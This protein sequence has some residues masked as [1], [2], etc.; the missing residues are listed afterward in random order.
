LDF[1]VR[2]PRA[3]ARERD[4]PRTK[5]MPHEVPC[6]NSFQVRTPTPGS[7]RRLAASRA[8]SAGLK[9]CQKSVSQRADANPMVRTVR[10]SGAVKG[11][12]VSGEIGRSAGDGARR[13]STQSAVPPRSRRV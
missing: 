11:R 6:S 8:G 3:A 9:P 2:V 7:R 5:K 10:A 12:R 13:R 1:G 4:A